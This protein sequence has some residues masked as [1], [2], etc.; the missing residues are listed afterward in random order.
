MVYVFLWRPR[1]VLMHGHDHARGLSRHIIWQLVRDFTSIVP[2]FPVDP[3]SHL[4]DPLLRPETLFSTKG[5][6][7][8]VSFVT[9]LPSDTVCHSPPSIEFIFSREICP[10]QPV[11]KYS[12]PWL[13]RRFSNSA[14]P[15]T[16]PLFL[17]VFFLQS[18]P[19]AV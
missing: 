11:T 9:T 10:R 3:F 6:R 8:L 7:R 2:H 5:L 19:Y 14:N 15:P 16:V 1:F 17:P 18:C 12:G 13:F 4:Q